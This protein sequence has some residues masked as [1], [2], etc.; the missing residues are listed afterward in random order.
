MAAYTRGSRKLRARQNRDPR[1]TERRGVSD[2]QEPGHGRDRKTREQ[3]QN[4]VTLGSATEAAAKAEMA[5]QKHT[6]TRGHVSYSALAPIPA[7]QL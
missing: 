4:S 5:A 6:H 3:S 1:L 2:R 7:L